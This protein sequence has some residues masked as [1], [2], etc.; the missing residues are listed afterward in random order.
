[1]RILSVVRTN[2]YGRPCVPEPLFLYFTQPLRRMGNDVETFDHFEA[3]RTNGRDGATEQLLKK[4]RDGAFDLV[5]YQ[6]SGK[7]PVDTAALADLAQKTC[8]AA[9]NS[10]DDWQWETTRQLASHF[11]HMITTYPHIYEG[12]RSTCHNLLLSQWGCLGLFSDF[13]RKKDID[14]SFAGAIYA[15]RSSACR[16]LRR[17]AG[18]DYFGPGAR[19]LRLGVPYFRGAFRL[20]WISGV[21]LG[22]EEIN[23]IWNRTRVSYTPMAGGPHG[24][25]VSLKSRLFDMGLSGTQC[26]VST[27]PTSHD[28]MSLAGSA[29]P[30]KHWRTAPRKL[31]GISRTNPNVLALLGIIT[32]ERCGNTCG[33]SD[34]RISS[35]R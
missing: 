17:R 10:D 1:M 21:A 3:R 25:V 19:L 26:C 2:Y 20:T 32:S 34:S 9:W 24:E 8:L 29:S 11:T 13:G 4:I 16:Y 12:N 7:E 30:S 18:L 35:G 33:N 5:L 15:A 27:V 6:T 31:C 22:F 14:F 28:I 23:N